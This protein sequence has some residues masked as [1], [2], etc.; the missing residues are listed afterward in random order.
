MRNIC[1]KDRVEAPA[2]L[3]EVMRRYPEELYD[4]G[5]VDLVFM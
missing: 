2:R 1:F 5:V 3:S 4:T